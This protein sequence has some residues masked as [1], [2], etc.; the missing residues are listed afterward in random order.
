M[1]LDSLL[2]GF[3]RAGRELHYC[4]LCK[5]VERLGSR[6]LVSGRIGIVDVLPSALE[7]VGDLPTY[8]SIHDV[9]GFN[10]ANTVVHICTAP[11]QHLN[12][13]EQAVEAGF[14]SFII[15][16]PMVQ[17]MGEFEQ[18]A[19]LQARYGLKIVGVANW[20]S[21]P[22][23]LRIRQ[24]IDS[25]EL[26]TLF[27]VKIENSK[28]RVSRTLRNKS[29]ST[30]FDVEMPHLVGLALYLGGTDA[31]LLDASC[32]DLRFIDDVVPHMGSASIQLLHDGKLP[33]RLYSSL[34]SPMRKRHVQLDFLHGSVSAYYPCG[35][36]D[37]C[38]WLQI[39]DRNGNVVAREVF[40]DDTLS[41][42]FIEYYKYFARRGP[43]PQ[44]D[45][46]FNERLVDLLHEAKAYCGILPDDGAVLR[47]KSLP[48]SGQRMA[49]I[50]SAARSPLTTKLV[51]GL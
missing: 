20:L 32:S 6:D 29:H 34:E 8:R 49:P 10:P 23:T 5:T 37:S 30:C 12:S 28:P 44:S 7:D 25:N 47:E 16:K 42:C 46:Q 18:L 3:G 41:S 39:S 50:L 9:K 1:S 51:E 48:R 24:M 15:E 43:A 40:E 26:G 2:F 19:S 17:T 22:L 31:R 11:L 4:C 27:N 38:S 45:L 35:N 33:C 36:D 13:V 14:R 21:A